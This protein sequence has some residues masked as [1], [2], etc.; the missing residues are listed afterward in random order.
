MSSPNTSPLDNKVPHDLPLPILQTK[1]GRIPTLED[2]GPGISGPDRSLSVNRF[3]PTVLEDEMRRN[4]AIP[5]VLSPL[6]HIPK[7]LLGPAKVERCQFG[8]LNPNQLKMVQEV[9]ASE[10]FLKASTFREQANLLNVHI[11]SNKDNPICT[12][13]ELALIFGLKHGESFRHQIEAHK[14]VAHEDG[15][16]PILHKEAE[17]FISKIVLERYAHQDSISIYEILDLLIDRFALPISIDTFRHYLSR[18]PLFKMATG[19]AIDSKRAKINYNHIKAWYNELEILI[20]H[21]PRNFIFNVDESGCDE[22]VDS[23]NV[24]VVVPKVHKDATVDIPVQR[25]CKR[26]TLTA[27]VA[28][29]GSSLVPFIILP[30]E[31]VDEEI[32]RAGYTPDKVMFFHHIHAFMTQKI[33]EKWMT[34]IFI[35]SLQQRRAETSYFGQAILIMD[36]FSGHNF[37]KLHALCQANNIVIKYLIPH[38]SHLC[39]PLDLVT[40]ASLKKIFNSYKPTIAR[41]AQSNKIIKLLHAWQQSNAIDTTISTFSAA[42]IV[43][44]RNYFKPFYYCSVDLSISIHL[45]ELDNLIAIQT[46]LLQ[47]ISN[48]ESSVPE[49]QHIDGLTSTQQRQWLY[50]PVIELPFERQRRIQLEKINEPNSSPKKAPKNHQEIKKANP[51]PTVQDG[52]PTLIQLTLLQTGL[53]KPQKEHLAG[54]AAKSGSSESAQMLAPKRPDQQPRESSPLI[55]DESF[56]D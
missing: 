29:D 11:R 42:G 16:P 3:P 8:H 50:P 52:Q 28:A 13:E 6:D 19:V 22:Y 12:Y 17:E 44:N 47:T 46:Q 34:L 45:K 54:G 35:P 23:Q 25:Q 5:D 20:K 7:S 33:F 9:F 26:A 31:T 49:Q 48:Q 30:R 51:L 24:T 27:C 37:D 10:A 36:N 1:W 21:V 55:G 32:F 4:R 56:L 15:R 53:K 40:F 14:K 41:T 2:F 43:S 38:T 18:H 39:Q